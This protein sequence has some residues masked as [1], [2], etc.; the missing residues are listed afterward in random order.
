MRAVGTGSLR[1]VPGK[2]ALNI[3]IILALA[4]VVAFLPGGRSGASL[5]A[6]VLGAGVL[7][8]IV[9]IIGRLYRE[10]RMTLFMLGDRVRGILY[11]SVALIVF[12]MAARNRLFDTDGGAV[13]WFVLMALAAAGLYTAI[14]RWRA[15]RY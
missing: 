8:V 13:V 5:I 3:L 7:T 9:L 12:A 6:S 15:E 1:S 2:A 11:A 14:Q 10:H 4:A